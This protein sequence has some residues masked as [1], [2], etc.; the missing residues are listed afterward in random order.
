V[1][2]QSRPSSSKVVDRQFGPVVPD[3]IVKIVMCA[4]DQPERLQLDAERLVPVPFFD[5]PADQINTSLSSESAL[6]LRRIEHMIVGFEVTVPKVLTHKPGIL[7]HQERREGAAS[8]PS[9]RKA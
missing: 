8:K 4:S 2:R 5:E 9:R 6:Y 3:Y 1:H 7:V